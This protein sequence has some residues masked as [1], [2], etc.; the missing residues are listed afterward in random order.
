M[1]SLGHNFAIFNKHLLKN[2]FR[3]RTIQDSGVYNGIGF[4]LV[5]LCVML[6]WSAH[7]LKSTIDV[8]LTIK[9]GQ[10]WRPVDV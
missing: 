3:N 5:A 1:F 6:L 10:N 8:T 4:V 2:S 7:F 9:K